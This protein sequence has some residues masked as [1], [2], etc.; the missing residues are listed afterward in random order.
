MAKCSTWFALKCGLLLTLVVLTNHGVTERLQVMLV[1]ERLLS[2]TIFSLIWLVS[3]VAALAAAFQPSLLVRLLWAIP[4][5]ISSAAAHGYYLVQGSEFSIFDVLNFWAARHEVHRASE[6]YSD[7]VWSSV[8]VFALGIVAIAIPPSIG[9]WRVRMTRYCSPWLPMLP[10]LLIAGVVIAR[11]GKGSQA[12]PKQFAPLSLAAVAAYKINTGAFE[13][14]QAVSMIPGPPLARAV[15]LVVDE[16]IRSDFVSLEHGNTITPE[17]ASLRERLIDFSPA[18]SSGNCSHLSN[19]MLRFM[20]DRRDL[21]RSVHTS[22]TVWQYAKAAGYRTVFID[23]QPRSHFNAVGGKLQNYMTPAEA[24]LIDRFYK[25][26]STFPL[27]AVDDELV[28]IALEEMSAGGPVFIYANKNGAH[29]PYSDG[30]PEGLPPDRPQAAGAD[31]RIFTTELQTY[32]KAVRWSTDRT[33]SRMIR[34]AD[35]SDATIIYT[36][37]HGQNFTPG[38]L[39]HC[40]T[41]ANVDPHEAIVPLIVLSGDPKLQNRFQGV[42]ER[43]RGHATH[44]AIAPTVLEL[45][46]YKPSEIAT[47]YEDSLLRALTWEPQFV[48]DDI[49]GLFSTQPTWHSANP[50]LLQKRYRSLDALISGLADTSAGICEDKVL[51]DAASLH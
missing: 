45:M 34:E 5:A 28:R 40:T 41:S 38:R 47:R 32:A 23:A 50:L 26:D 15:V 27:H 12:M 39:T 2:L 24:L 37:D 25:F 33:I 16:S 13:E 18:V 43:Y 22:P 6:F 1:D 3:L 21:V 35:L 48:S 10:V 44:F 20:V 14:R 49:L 17:L 9:P 30:S 51:C 46:G 8:A 19:A 7:A 31:A 4:L 36:S 29:F 42:A 11:D